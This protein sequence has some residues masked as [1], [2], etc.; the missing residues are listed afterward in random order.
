VQLYYRSNYH[1]YLKQQW[2]SEG[3]A[4][5]CFDAERAHRIY[6]SESRPGD[7]S[8]VYLFPSFLPPILP[9]SLCAGTVL[10][11]VDLDWEIAVSETADSTVV[12]VDGSKLQFTGAFPLAHAVSR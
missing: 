11:V 2:V 8:R 6:M 1:W 12:V 9:I 5:L 3:L 7:G 4:L 10:R